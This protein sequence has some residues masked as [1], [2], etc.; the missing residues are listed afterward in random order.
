MSGKNLAQNLQTT[1]YIEIPRLNRR[2]ERIDSV[3]KKRMKEFT[4]ERRRRLRREV[5]Q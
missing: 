2:P 3:L 5:Q 4:R 1:T